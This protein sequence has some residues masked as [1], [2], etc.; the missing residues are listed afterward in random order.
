[1]ARQI[2]GAVVVVDALLRPEAR[3][4]AAE[5]LSGDD[6]WR[7]FQI[8]RQMME[9]L[10]AAEELAKSLKGDPSPDAKALR[11][12][13][14]ALMARVDAYLKVQRDAEREARR[15]RRRARAS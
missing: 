1:M 12:T 6:W 3:A 10:G 8:H 14:K 15:A 2:S 5:E 7:D 13:M 9:T 4:A 11:A